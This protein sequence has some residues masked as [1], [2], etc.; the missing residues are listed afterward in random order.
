MCGQITFK[1]LV[2]FDHRLLSHHNVK[3]QQLRSTRNTSISEP[4]VTSHPGQL[5]LA[6][7]SC[8]WGVKAGMVRVSRQ[9]KLC[10]PLVTHGQYLSTL[11]TEYNK[12]LYKFTFFAF[13]TPAYRFHINSGKSMHKMDT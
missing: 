10:D 13:F 11:E 3:L 9:V 12:A 2:L 1:R 5:S 6:I 4:Y 8:G 7:P